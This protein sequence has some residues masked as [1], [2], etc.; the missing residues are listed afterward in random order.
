MGG[1]NDRVRGAFPFVQAFPSERV[2]VRLMRAF[3]SLTVLV[4]EDDGFVREDMVLGL[5]QEG[6]IVLEAATGAGALKVLR[7][8]ETIDLLITDILLADA[9]TGWD[10]AEAFRVSRPLGPVI[11]ASGNPDNVVRRVASSVFLSKP[12]IMA[13]LLVA[14]R[15]VLRRPGD[16]PFASDLVDRSR[17]AALREMP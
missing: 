12:V 10:V 14:C 4:V 16:S 1:R 7:E 9:L 13:V 11:Y 3:N 17:A 8:T 15:K 5:Q 2:G 6:W